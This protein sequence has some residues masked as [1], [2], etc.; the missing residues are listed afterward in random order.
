MMTKF[1]AATHV[2]QI[3]TTCR[4]SFH[5]RSGSSPKYALKSYGNATNI[6]FPIVLSNI[7]FPLS[8]SPLFFL[9][10]TNWMLLGMCGD[11]I[12]HFRSVTLEVFGQILQKYLNISFVMDHLTEHPR[13][14]LFYEYVCTVTHTVRFRQR[15]QNTFPMSNPFIHGQARQVYSSW[16]SPYY[17]LILRLKK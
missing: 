9:L 15:H 8:F 6:N 5:L 1:W 14:L 7:T 12:I 16:F 4:F 13:E 11:E 10:F 3:I 2:A 17:F